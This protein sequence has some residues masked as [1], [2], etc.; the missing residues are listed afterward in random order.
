ME[1]MAKPVSRSWGATI[2]YLVGALVSF[3]ISAILFITIVEG[4]ITIGIA[5]IPAV[6]G[7]ILI[8]MSF[9]GSGRSNCPACNS[10]LSGLSTKTNDGV[11]CPYCHKYSEGKGGQLW[12]SAEDRIAEEPLF[13]SPLP[14]RFNLPAGC[15]ICGASEV[16]REAIRLDMQNSSSVVTNAAVGLTTST[17]ISVEVPHCAQHNSEARL[18][19]TPKNPHIKFRSYPYLRQF[20]ELNGTSPG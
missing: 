20:C 1:R 2:G 18:S 6:L 13:S 9:G 7:V 14:E 17:S 8:F 4:S 19:G 3:V 12:Q 10:A 16:N 11:L 5:L 15:C